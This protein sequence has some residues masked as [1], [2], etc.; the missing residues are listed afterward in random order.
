MRN[1]S[2]MFHKLLR[3]LGRKSSQKPLLSRALYHSHLVHINSMSGYS[4]PTRKNHISGFYCS[5]FLMRIPS[6][7]S[8]Q[9]GSFTAASE[10]RDYGNRRRLLRTQGLLVRLF[11]LCSALNPGY[12]LHCTLLVCNCHCRWLQQA[13]P[14]HE[15][16]DGES[17]LTTSRHSI[18]LNEDACACWEVTAWEVTGAV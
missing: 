5:T 13:L 11:Q 2:S 17:H 1:I 4:N 3:C 16:K 6:V 10:N 14:A 8:S 18:G 7:H 15:Q 12:A 9:T